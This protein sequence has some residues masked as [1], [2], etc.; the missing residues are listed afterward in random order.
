MS[1]ITLQLITSINTKIN[2][3]IWDKLG[4]VLLVFT[5]VI[6]TV[7][8]RFFQLRHLFC[9]I[10]QPFRSMIKKS[11]DSTGSNITQIQALCTS[12][13]ST[14]GVGSVV[15]V[16]SA[17]KTGGSGA[18]FW[19]LV[20]AFFSMMTAYCE[21]VL[22]IYF[23]QKNKDGKWQGGTMYVLKNAAISNTHLKTIFK[24]LSILFC[25]FCILASFG[26][27]NLGQVNKITENLIY[28]FPISS[29][30][31]K[32]I[33]NIP[34]YNII[35]AVIL[36]LLCGFII[37]GG[38]KRIALFA[39]KIVPFM[40]LFFISGSL[41]VIFYHRENISYAVNSILDNA[42]SANALRGA[43]GGISLKTII[44]TGCKRGLFSTEA[45]M[46]STTLINSSSDVKEPA[47]Q[48]MWGIFQVFVDTFLICTMTALVIL[49]SKVSFNLSDSVMVADAFSTVF[50]KFG[51]K[52]VAVS[53]L[54]FAL[55][56]TIGWSQYATVAVEYLKIPLLNKLYKLLFIGIIPLGCIITSNFAWNICDTFNGLMMIPNLIALLCLFPTVIKIHNNYCDRIFKHKKISPMLS[57]DKQI[58]IKHQMALKREK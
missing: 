30:T 28:S 3:F 46:G 17:I 11:K 15:G 58:Q 57:F 42:F 9:W 47:V 7:S 12:L 27:G 51:N 43:A 19:M 5:G 1:E 40:V 39:E 49:T 31:N 21:N 24:I 38:L 20:A 53:I 25:I 41:I 14:I 29:L 48:G 33:F 32:T 37:T 23:R 50:G 35:I 2:T 6:F 13:A 34:L 52:F 45:G 56:S 26:I 55:T 18:V 4:L 16:S 44:T 22:S 54:M 8:T 36:T 10:S